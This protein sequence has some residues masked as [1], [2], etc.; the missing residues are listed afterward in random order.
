MNKRVL[1]LGQGGQLARAIVQELKLNGIEYLALS[2]AELDICHAPAVE[3]VFEK[4]RP[5]WVI[6]CAAYTQVDLAETESEQA[7]LVNAIAVSSLSRICN[8]FSAILVH[9]STDYVYHNGKNRPLVETDPCKPQSVYGQSKLA[10]EKAIRKA[11]GCYLIFRI[12][13][14][15]AP[16]GRN[17]FHTMTTLASKHP[18]IKVVCDQIGAPTY[19]PDIAALL[20]RII[21]RTQP[22][23]I[24]EISGVY[25]LAQT[26]VASWYDFARAIILPQFPDKEIIPVPTDIF[27]RPAA[28]PSFSVMNLEKFRSQFQ[29]TLRHWQSCV[30][31]CLE[32]K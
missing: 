17:F 4:L 7:H 6:N 5:D 13:W 31:D 1:V 26:G 18:E 25:N 2:Q 9:F 12:S 14:L 28:R 22:N 32:T 24:G 10:G 16:W 8:R 30:I 27:P 19:A 3:A 21:Q 23:E 29:F 20:T 15:F 11:G